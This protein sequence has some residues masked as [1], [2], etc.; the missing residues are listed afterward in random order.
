M[1]NSHHTELVLIAVRVHLF[2]SRTQKLSSFASTIL[3]GRLA[4]KIDNAN[5]TRPHPNGCGL[6]L[7][8]VLIGLSQ[9]TD[10]L[11][12]ERMRFRFSV[13]ANQRARWCGNPPVGREMYRYLLYRVVNIA[14]LAEIITW[15]HSSGG[16][17]HQ[18]ADWFAMTARTYKQQFTQVFS[19]LVFTVFKRTSSLL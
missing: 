18:S 9:P 11:V 15:F 16:L 6:T 13:I 10:K 19:K 4:G 1:V 2:P 5:T 7:Y 17:P 8:Y 12:F 14:F 3:A